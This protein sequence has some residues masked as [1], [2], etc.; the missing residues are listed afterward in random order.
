MRARFCL[1]CV[2][3]VPCFVWADGPTAKDIERLVRRLGSED[4]ETREAASKALNDLGEAALPALRAALADRA[5][6]FDRRSPAVL[7][8]CGRAGWHGQETR[9]LIT[10]GRLE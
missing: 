10:S 6:S 7:E 5:A 8:T 4:F 1:V 9:A 3:A 2:V